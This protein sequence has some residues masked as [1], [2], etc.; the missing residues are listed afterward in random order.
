MTTAWFGIISLA[1]YSARYMKDAFK[2]SLFGQKLW[3]QV[4]FEIFVILKI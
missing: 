4:K 2:S 1:I 3:F